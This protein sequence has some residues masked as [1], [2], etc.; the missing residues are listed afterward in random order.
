MMAKLYK[1]K[2]L[3]GNIALFLT[4]IL[5]LA[6]L[7]FGSLSWRPWRGQ[8][9]L[10]V[11]FPLSGGL[12]DTSKVT[13]RGVEVGDVESISVQP[14]FVKVKLKIDDDVKINKNATFSAL[15]L[16]AAGEQYV[17]IVP[18]TADGPFLKDGDVIDVSQTHVTAAFSSL[19]QSTLDVISQIDAPKLTASL[20]QLTIALNDQGPNQLK[21][22]FQ[23]GGAIFADLAR[24]LPQTTKL[25][26]N[27]GTI[28]RTTADVQPDLQRLVDG[29]S[30]VVNSAVAAD[31][32]LRTLLGTGPAR[33]TSLTASLD[34]ITDPVSDVLKQFLD[35]ARQGAL[36]AP[37]LAELLPSIRD[38][39][40]QAQKMFHDGAWWA[41][42]SLYPRPYCD[43]PV[44]PQRPTKILEAS[45]PVNLYCASADQNQQR[46]GSNNAPRP[47]GD[48]TAGPPANFDA[49][50]RTVPLDK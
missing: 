37:T 19:L 9:D 8:Y 23:S 44:T 15:G 42:A 6:Y 4:M 47:T 11:N 25:I 21:S 18:K 34:T 7:S 48:D 3:I 26:Q 12:Q 39:S 40:A 16:S 22:I 2:I 10:T 29:G 5:G 32:E 1:H 45:V 17:D 33:L 43:Y 31:V 36:R 30:E 50:G 35:V 49:N 24:V 41:M 27:S 46:R 38:G 20:S 13:L 28:L 14:K